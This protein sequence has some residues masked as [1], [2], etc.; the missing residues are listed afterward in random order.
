MRPLNER[1]VLLA[2]AENSDATDRRTQ[3]T[4]SG[5]IQRQAE[6][7]GAGELLLN[8]FRSYIW[9]VNELPR[10]LLVEEA[11]FRLGPH[12]QLGSC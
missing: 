8:T 7:C 10:R 3:P 2:S 11:P 6:R 5:L 9:R 4:L 1:L 12:H